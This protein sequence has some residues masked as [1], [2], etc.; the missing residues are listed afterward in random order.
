MRAQKRS[1]KPAAAAG[2]PTGSLPGSSADV[3]VRPVRARDLDSVIAIDEQITGIGKADYWRERFLRYGGRGRQP[4][5]FL[6]AECDGEI[7]GFIIG[8]VRDWEFGTPPC[9]WVFGISVRREARLSGI[10]TRLL[11]AL[12]SSFRKAGVAKVRTLLVF[13]DMLV[14]TFYRSQGMMAAPIIT[15]ERNLTETIIE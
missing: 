1:K 8:E 15:L 11:D 3:V 14:M 9:G 10:G 2:A 7:D 12:C 5:F 13:D 4:C 6:V